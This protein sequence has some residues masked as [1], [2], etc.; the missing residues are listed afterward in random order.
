MATL[1]QYTEWIKRYLV[2]DTTD[3]SNSLYPDDEI[4]AAV[5]AAQCEWVSRLGRKCGLFRKTKTTNATVAGVTIETDFLSNLQVRFGGSADGRSYLPCTT[6]DVLDER[7]P[8]W[9]DETAT[10][11]THYYLTLDTDGTTEINFY[12]TLTT[13]VTNGLFYSYTAKPTALS[14]G[15]DIAKCMTWFPQLDPLALPAYAMVILLNYEGGTRD[16]Q[17]GKWDGIFEAQIER[18]RGILKYMNQE[19]P[20]YKRRR[21]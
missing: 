12:P 18:A 5:N 21:A 16:D 2:E 7:N 9:R 3:A 8:N 20:S 13:A 1:T 11:P 17:I 15:A 4:T 10:S 19:Y 14:A 6:V